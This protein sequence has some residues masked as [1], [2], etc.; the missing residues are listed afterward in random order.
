MSARSTVRR[1][2]EKTIGKERTKRIAR[3][4]RARSG[5]PAVAPDT[6]ELA[7]HLSVIREELIRSRT[8]GAGKGGGRA[9]QRTVDNLQAIRRELNSGRTIPSVPIVLR[10]RSVDQSVDHI[11][12]EPEFADVMVATKKSECLASALRATTIDGMVCEFGVYK[13]ESLTQIAQYFP[14]RTVHGFDSF[15]G[16]PESW[17][18]TSKNA[19]AFDIG[20]T[21]PPVPVDN[22]EFHVGFFDT[23]VPKFEANHQGPFAFVHLDADLYSSTKT[24]MDT[25]FD[26]FVPG[27]VIVFDEYFGYHGWQNHEHKAFME[28]LERSGFGYEAIAVGHMNLGVRLTEGKKK[29]A[30]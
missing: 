11:L 17:S 10:Q 13:G 4:V 28:L 30:K 22:V 7:Y 5:G 25:L 12:N 23:T 1:G 6:K 19:G 21:P 15:I 26:W 24:V 8:G 27:T 20:G 2:L 9:D 18:G 3:A 29:A 16:L 14:D